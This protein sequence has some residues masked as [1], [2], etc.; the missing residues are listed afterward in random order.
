MRCPSHT[1]SKIC[2]ACFGYCYLYTRRH[3]LNLSVRK[4]SG[5][6]I[7]HVT[8]TY[9]V[10]SLFLIQFTDQHFLYFFYLNFCLHMAITA[11]SY[12]FNVQGE[13][14]AFREV[15][16]RAEID[17]TPDRKRNFPLVPQT[18]TFVCISNRA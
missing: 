3:M 4:N 12:L 16:C 8:P 17:R 10:E 14:C 6:L 1:S 7:S 13:Y 2:C 11:Y 5:S 18:E 15:V 9:R